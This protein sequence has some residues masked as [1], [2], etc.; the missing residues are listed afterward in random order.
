MIEKFRKSGIS[1]IGDTPW[2][3]HIC[4]FYETKEDLLRF[5]IPYFKAGLKNNEFC[6][7]VTSE[8]VTVEDAREAL[9]GAM[10]NFYRYVETGQIEMIPYKDW[11][12]KN[13]TFESGDVLNRWIDKLNEALTNGYDGCE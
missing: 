5:L 1:S 8:P 3:S 9:T 4:Q 10:P 7:W 13:D 2:G 6:M 11:Y 12:L